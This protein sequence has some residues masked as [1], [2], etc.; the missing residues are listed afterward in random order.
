LAESFKELNRYGG[1]ETKNVA[2]QA[3]YAPVAPPV[4]ADHAYGMPE[5]RRTEAAAPRL[6][7]LWPL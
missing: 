7:L 4:G 3:E 1:P 2:I 5:L 6:R